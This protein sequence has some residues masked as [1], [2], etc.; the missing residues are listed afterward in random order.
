[1]SHVNLTAAVRIMATEFPD[2]TAAP[3]VTAGE[4]RR[5]AF[6]P[7]PRIPVFAA[8]HGSSAGRAA[9]QAVLDAVRR[10]IRDA[11]VTGAKRS[12]PRR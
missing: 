7:L 5:V 1:M 12:R 3:A 2:L 4:L 10:R 11:A 8:R 6:D 9:V